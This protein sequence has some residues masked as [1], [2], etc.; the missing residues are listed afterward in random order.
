MSEPPHPLAEDRVDA[1]FAP[2]GALEQTLPHYE[3]RPEQRAVAAA[4]TR[5][6]RESRTLL[7]EAGTGTGKSLAY[8]VPVLASG[9][10]AV[11]STATRNLQDQLFDKDLP[12][13]MAA[14]GVELP[15]SVMKGRSNYVCLVRAEAATAQ[16]ELLERK[17]FD[18]SFR[19]WLANTQNGD[20]A[21]LT[22]LPE[23]SPFRREI[24]ATAEQCLGR[25]CPLYESCYV[26]QMRRRAQEA[27]LVLVN[28]HL[29]FA[30][31]AL[32]RS[33][34]DSTTSLLPEHKVVVFD[35]AHELDDIAARHFGYEL[36]DK[37]IDE[38]VLDVSNRE[39]P[40]HDLTAVLRQVELASRRL[41]DAFP[42][43]TSPMRFMPGDA[44]TRRHDRTRAMQD[45]LDELTEQLDAEGDEES[46]RL[47]RR[48]GSIRDALRVI[49]TDPNPQTQE[50]EV[51]L[52]DGRTLDM[53]SPYR[54]EGVA[55]ELKSTSPEE[56][57]V[58]FTERRGNQ[59]S[60]VACPSDIASMFRRY[61][62]EI[63]QVYVSATLTVNGSFEYVRTRL[64]IEDAEEFQVGSP[65]D[66]P[67]S[68]RLYLPNDLP[69]PDQNDFSDLAVDRARSLIEAARGGAFVL[70][71]S[72]RMVQAMREGLKGGT[73]LVLCQ[74]EAPRGRLIEAFRD[75]GDAVLIGTMSL[76]RGVDVAGSALRL[77]I[78]D[79]LP[80]GHPQD[81]MHQGR[82]E[83][84]KANG[85]EPFRHY[86]LPQ[87]ALLLRQGFGR[88]LRRQDDRGVV[89]ILDPRLTRRGYGK[90]LLRSLPPC[91]R[92]ESLEEVTAFF[93]GRG[94]LP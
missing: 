92:I 67:R 59:R 61:L 71:T 23:S 86:Q 18:H 48:S 82:I 68:A 69:S 50:V 19:A 22:T 70:C 43:A 30:D 24:T 83:W 60:L 25:R 2:G 39:S 42:F 8:L 55:F 45:T 78:I 33:S 51:P 17:G 57:M 9:E 20:L 85:R 87:A 41:F 38:L 21:E 79:R 36:S 26:T 76:W 93:S 44:A 64:G 94:E 32:R 10:K 84:A 1:F 53:R 88:L 31:L 5:A 11:V 74:G 73:S 75:H 34:A 46:L 16:G 80:F 15:V 62:P 27:Q 90:V 12:D 52:E 40:M 47:A 81:P 72:H 58:R 28:H 91:P 6:L 35:E 7:A 14:A 54:D 56:A 77:V 3:S 4:V 37:R 13:V 65:F 63:P 49:L 89:A 66:Y 29:Y